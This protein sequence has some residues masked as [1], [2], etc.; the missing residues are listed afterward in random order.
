[1]SARLRDGAV[2]LLRTLP[3]KSLTRECKRQLE[4]LG[5]PQL[6][7]VEQP[8]RDRDDRI[9]RQKDFSQSAFVVKFH[10]V[11]AQLVQRHSLLFDS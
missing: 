3:E 8:R 11:T 2:A 5:G 6:P 7:S 9:R 1:M 4:F 10:S